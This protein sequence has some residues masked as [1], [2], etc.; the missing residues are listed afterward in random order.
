VKRVSTQALLGDRV[1]RVSGVTVTAQYV[2]YFLHVPLSHVNKVVDR[3]MHNRQMLEW[4][5]FH[6][7]A[8]KS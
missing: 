7:E 3:Q 4:S 8:P 6:K 1:L 2:A 5:M